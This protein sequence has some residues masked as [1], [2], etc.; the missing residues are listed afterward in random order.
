MNDCLCREEDTTGSMYPRPGSSPVQP[1]PTSAHKKVDVVCDALRK[2]M[3]GT[4][5]NK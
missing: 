4:D 5:P 2:T 3:E 1:P